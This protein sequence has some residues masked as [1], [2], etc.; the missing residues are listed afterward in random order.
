V[1]G[2]LSQDY[3]AQRGPTRICTRKGGYFKCAWRALKGKYDIRLEK[4]SSE[5]TGRSLE[6]FFFLNLPFSINPYPFPFSIRLWFPLHQ[7]L[8]I[9]DEAARGSFSKGAYFVGKLAW[10]KGL[11]ELFQV[12]K[13]FLCLT[14]F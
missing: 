9:G 10:P 12:F 13:M 1:Q 7:Y 2:L 11:G 6:T 14:K 8:E 3:K 4:N 5:F